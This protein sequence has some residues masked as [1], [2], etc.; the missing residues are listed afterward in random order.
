MA[1]YLNGMVVH[2]LW[3]MNKVTA[4]GWS[5]TRKTK[6]NHTFYWV[7]EGEGEF[8]SD[9]V[10][11]V[12]RGTLTYLPPGPEMHMRSSEDKPLVIMMVRFDSAAYVYSDRQWRL[13]PLERLEL[14]LFQQFEGEMLIKLDRLF[15]A[16][17]R[18]WVPTREGG[19]LLSRAHLMTIMERVH[20]PSPFEGAND[21]PQQAFQ[22]IKAE[23]EENFQAPLQ[24]AELASRHSVSPSYLRKMFLRQLGVSPKAYL[25]RVRNEHAQRYLSYSD[26]PMHTIA[27]AC[28]YQDE[29][30]FSKA[31]KKLNGC[32]PTVFRSLREG[33]ST[34]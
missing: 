7:R 17:G 15:E 6:T 22:R 10:R 23:I 26:I 20:Q 25:S 28:G 32:A 18:D 30:Q 19:E 21:W 8:R 1:D 12:R 14:P 13:R 16:L 5:D 11:P 24:I 2:V 3:L 29:F 31:F 27:D 9:D 4:N 33:P 34:H